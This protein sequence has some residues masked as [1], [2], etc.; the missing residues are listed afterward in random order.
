[1]DAAYSN[2]SHCWLCEIDGR[3]DSQSQCKNVEHAGFRCIC[4]VGHA[5]CVSTRH[6]QRDGHASQPGDEETFFPVIV[7]TESYLHAGFPMGGPVPAPT[8]QREPL[9]YP[10]T[11]AKAD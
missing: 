4:L 11:Q 7:S 6:T 10:P 3:L 2:S 5:S 9:A 8:Q 1:M